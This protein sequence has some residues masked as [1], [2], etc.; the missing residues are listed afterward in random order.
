MEKVDKIVVQTTVSGKQCWDVHL[1][2]GQIYKF[3]GIEF[4]SFSGG[5]YEEIDSLDDFKVEFNYK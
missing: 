1:K 5:P 3:S 4:V 2:D